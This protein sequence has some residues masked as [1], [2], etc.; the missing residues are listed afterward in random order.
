MLWVHPDGRLPKTNRYASAK[1][2]ARYVW[3]YGHRNI[4]G[5][6][7]RPSTGRLYTAEHGPDRDDEVNHVVK[8]ANYGWNPVPGYNES[9]PMTDRRKYPKAGRAIWS[10]GKPT[11]ATSGLTF[12]T[13]RAWENWN[14]ALAVAQL[15]GTGIRL[16]FL[17]RAGKVTGTRMVPGSSAY[18]RIRTVQMGPDAALYFTTSNGSRDRIVKVTPT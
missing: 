6:T 15:K 5:L 8:R 4:Q 7:V 1:G 14:G 13:G 10:S 18:G 12:V 17:D 11:V 9:R 16:L 3:N 2:K